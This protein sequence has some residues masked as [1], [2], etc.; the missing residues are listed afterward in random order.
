MFCA[1]GVRGSRLNHIMNTVI[2]GAEKSS[3]K[4]EVGKR[5]WP[6]VSDSFTSHRGAAGASL[7]RACTGSHIGLTDDTESIV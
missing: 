3:S 4:L 6:T 1:L 5:K 7:P 2:T